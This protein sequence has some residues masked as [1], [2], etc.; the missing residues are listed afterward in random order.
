M[1]P[2]RIPSRSTEVAWGTQRAVP[3]VSLRGPFNN[4]AA[5]YDA[6]VE[7]V[8]KKEGQVFFA[9]GPGGSGKTF[10]EQALLHNVRGGGEVA[11]ACAWSGVAATLLEGGKTCHST[12]GFPVPM[13]AE[14]VPCSISAQSG[15]A[16]VLRAAQLIVWDEAPMSPSEAVTAADHLLRDL[17][18]TDRPFGGKT[19]LFAGD[20]R[21]V[22]PVM[23]HSSRE[24]ILA[25]SL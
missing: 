9:D 16:D 5:L 3:V 20:F 13:P 12:F 7:S 23:P 6:I 15:R 25:H 4:Q 2:C 22:L 1:L 21:Q 8:A 24:E 10:V 18:Q 14:D 19:I 17:C 11:L